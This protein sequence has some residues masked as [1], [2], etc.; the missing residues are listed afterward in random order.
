MF[1]S[2]KQPALRVLAALIAV[3]AL[4]A[5]AAGVAWPDIYKYVA[6][7]S[8]QPF[9]FGQDL[10]SMAAAVLLLA[11][12]RTKGPMANVLKFGI[13]GY[14]F[15][16]YG[17]YLMG[18]LYT[19]Y[20]FLYLAIFGLTIFYFIVAFT[21]IDYAGTQFRMPTSLRI[22]VAI[23]CVSTAVYFA[24]QW[25]T[26]IL[27]NIQTHSGPAKTG[28][29][30]IYYVHILDMCFVLP[31]CVIACVQLLQKTVLGAVL[32]GT[33]SVMGAILMLSV[34]MGYF[35]QPLFRQTLDRA[36]AV[37]FSIL[38]AVFVVLSVFYFAYTQVERLQRRGD[39]DG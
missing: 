29:D 30:F 14:L 10:V 17:P 26:A 5:S 13:I 11:V 19:E 6:P 37:Q 4:I 22:A 32:G 18:T 24:P 21:G 28:F 1:K 2:E 9:L 25:V 20:Y 27:H 33:L 31:V 15:Y 16:A 3:T 39:C 35:C 34:A 7:T 36:N 12:W 23:Y 38:T 8:E